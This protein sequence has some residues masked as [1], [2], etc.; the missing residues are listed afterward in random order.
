[1]SKKE[2]PQRY[3]NTHT[4][5]VLTSGILL[6]S[7]IFLFSALKQSG[8]N[9]H[10]YAQGDPSAIPTGTVV[11]FDLDAC[12]DGWTQFSAANGRAIIGTSPGA[13]PI[14]QR[15]R[16]DIGGS[17]THLLTVEELPSHT[18]QQT[19][20]NTEGGGGWSLSGVYNTQ[21]IVNTTQTTGTT[22]GDEPH[23]NM[24][25]FVVLLYCIKT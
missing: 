6:S 3:N 21:G 2:A 4:A 16:G 11:A 7:L 10:I 5:L 22:G 19:V 15:T 25:P 18:H 20:W 12:P 13:G 23:N 8:S 17:E 24:Q 14:S 1:M 9:S